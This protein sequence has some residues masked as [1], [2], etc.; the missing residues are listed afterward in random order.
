MKIL[1]VDDSKLVTSSIF[2]MLNRYEVSV[3]IAHNY[4]DVID[5]AKLHQFDLAFI[6]VKMPVKSGIEIAKSLKN[7]KT[8][9]HLVMMTG[10]LAPSFSKLIPKLDPLDTILKPLNVEN[11]DKILK[12]IDPN[13]NLTKELPISSCEN[14]EDFSDIIF[15]A[16]DGLERFGGDI[17][18]YVKHLQN[19]LIELDKTIIELFEYSVFQ[20][21]TINPK[22]QSMFHFKIHNLKG[23][24]E[25][26]GA[27][28]LATEAKI[29]DKIICKN[30]DFS[31]ENYHDFKKSAELTAITISNFIS[32]LSIAA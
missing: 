13:L 24:S 25:F 3:H 22:T 14:I 18:L 5:L 23:N 12:K 30:E 27:S 11:I 17:N 29:L 9:K 28:Y 26:I 2:S 31:D 4:Y 20:T 32:S 1:I 21:E 10:V 8:I 15:N 19:F 16:S 7:S 6:D